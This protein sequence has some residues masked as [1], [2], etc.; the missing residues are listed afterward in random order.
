MIDIRVISQNNK[1]LEIIN[2]DQTI[3][4]VNN[5]NENIPLAYDS[6]C[7]Y[8]SP[9]V[10]KITYTSFLILAHDF[11]SSFIGLMFMITL[12]GLF[13]VVLKNSKRFLK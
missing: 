2:L 5:S 4:M 1:S 7:I 11:I 13:I 12:I 6:Y 8:V 3:N 9:L 10:A